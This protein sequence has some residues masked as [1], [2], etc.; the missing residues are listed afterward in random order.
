MLFVF[1]QYTKRQ[2]TEHTLSL[3]PGKKVIN[4]EHYRKS[5]K[6]V[7]EM[8]DEVLKKFPLV[9]WIEFSRA[10]F[11]R[12]S[13]YV[14]DQCIEAQRRFGKEVDPVCL[15]KALGFCLEHKTYSMANLHDTY[16]YYKGLS[17]TKETDLLATVRPQLKEISRYKKGIHVTQR[18]LGV[19]KSFLRVLMGVLG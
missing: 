12:Y 11:K 18:D 7:Q 17:E 19:Y 1:D 4:R 16:L 10:N 15:D 6:S 2:I 9:K 3:I 14:R 8:K 13:R 5:G